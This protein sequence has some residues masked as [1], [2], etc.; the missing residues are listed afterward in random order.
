MSSHAGGHLTLT[1][2]S[3]I[4][5]NGS[6]SSLYSLGTDLKENTA[7][8]IYTIVLT[9]PFH[10]N[11]CFSGST[12]PALADM[13]QYKIISCTRKETHYL[14]IYGFTPFVEPWPLFQFI[15]LLQRR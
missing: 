2:L 5:R 3:G 15:H 7:F 12:F 9:Q 14:F 4:F 11:G 6:W 1:S 8:T 13:P 10:S